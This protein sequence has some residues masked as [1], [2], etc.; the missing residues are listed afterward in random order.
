MTDLLTQK[1]TERVNFQPKKIRRNP[2][3]CILQVPPLGFVH[4][5]YWICPSFFP[6]KVWDEARI[7]FASEEN[8]EKSSSSF[9]MDVIWGY[10]STLK[11]GNGTHKFG[12]KWR[13]QNSS[14]S[15][16]FKC[17][18]RESCVSY[19]G[20]KTAFRQHLPRWTV[21]WPFCLLSKWPTKGH[22]LNHLGI[23]WP[24][25]RKLL[26]TTTKSIINAVLPSKIL[27]FGNKAT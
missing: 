1:N 26:E 27:L 10:L 14:Y 22:L 11:L 7:K 19:K 2:P 5:V 15:T 12:N 18:W 4:V 9:R 23:C 20:N 24:L 25:Q 3:S 13:G 8:D 21:R 16:T 6:K 17:R